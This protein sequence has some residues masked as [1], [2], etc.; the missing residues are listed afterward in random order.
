VLLRAYLGGAGCEAVLER[1]DEDLVG[2]VRAEFRI[3]M[4]IEEEPT[5]ARVYRWPHA[6]PQYLVGHL[7][8]LEV[9]EEMLTRLPGVF[10]TG[11]GYRG[12]GLPDCIRDGT[13]TADKVVRYFD[14]G[15]PR[16]LE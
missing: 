13:Q 12:V 3:I 10:L 6:M 15:P 1:T 14:K 8:R 2:L 9:M 16:P 4:G 7:D 11:A 5:L